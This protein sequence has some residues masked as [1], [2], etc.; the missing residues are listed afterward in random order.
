M[1]K[2]ILYIFRNL[3]E[4]D[5]YLQVK[6]DDIDVLDE[7]N[8]LKEEYYNSHELGQDKFL[9]RRFRNIDNSIEEIQENGDS[10][11]L[12]ILRTLLKTEF[13]RENIGGSVSFANEDSFVPLLSLFNR[14][15]HSVDLY[16]PSFYL[17]IY[18]VVYMDTVSIFDF[19]RSTFIRGVIQDILGKC[20]EIVKMNQ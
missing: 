16:K 18:D 7:Y 1:K 9:D 17:D 8:L 15:L 12:S 5:R 4:T 19:D 3:T 20:C 10:L 6:F 11:Y 13:S 14:D 2:S